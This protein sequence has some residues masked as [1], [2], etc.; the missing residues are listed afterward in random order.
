[1]GHPILTTCGTCHLRV[2]RTTILTV[3]R[4]ENCQQTDLASGAELTI[5]HLHP[6]TSKRYFNLFTLLAEGLVNGDQ[7]TRI[8]FLFDPQKPHDCNTPGT[9]EKVP[10]SPGS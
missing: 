5:V 6:F 10:R 4:F 2:L 9:S 3:L 8:H 1:M 7:D